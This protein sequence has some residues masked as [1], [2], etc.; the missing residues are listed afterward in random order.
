LDTRVCDAKAAAGDF[1]RA[2][3]FDCKHSSDFSDDDEDARAAAARPIGAA[4]T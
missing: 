1:R 4:E 3:S 2:C